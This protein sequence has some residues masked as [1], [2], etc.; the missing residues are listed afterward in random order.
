MS[1]EEGIRENLDPRQR[2]R[3]SVQ[4]MV[5]AK[6]GHLVTWVILTIP[7]WEKPHPDEIF[8]K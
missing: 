5:A 7:L 1:Q 3:T 2:E 6:R 8:N 4:L